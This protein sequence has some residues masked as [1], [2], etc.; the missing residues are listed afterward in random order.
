LRG[1]TSAKP[2]YPRSASGTEKPPSAVW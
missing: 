2:V 1:S